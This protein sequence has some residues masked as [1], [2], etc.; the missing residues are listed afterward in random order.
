[1]AISSPRGALWSHITVRKI[2]D[3]PIYS[4]ETVYNGENYGC[5]YPA[6]IDAE[7]TERI[8]YF[9]DKY[10]GKRLKARKVPQLY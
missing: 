4:G 2:L 5:L 9:N 1:M 3:N 6:I 10:K 7:M 8:A